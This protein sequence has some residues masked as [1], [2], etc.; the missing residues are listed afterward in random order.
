MFKRFSS[1]RSG[2]GKEA[3]VITHWTDWITLFR[4]LAWLPVLGLL[5][6]GLLFPGTVQSPTTMLASLMAGVL[7]LA[8]GYAFNSIADVAVDNPTKNPLTE[9]RLRT[10]TAILV[11]SIIAL[12]GLFMSLLLSRGSAL[13]FLSG[14]IFNAAYSFPPLRLKRFLWSN[15]ILN[16]AGFTMLA[17]I[18]AL[19]G[20]LPGKELWLLGGFIF[21]SLVPYQIIHLFTHKKSDP[22]HGLPENPVR[23]FFV[24]HSILLV[25]MALIGWLLRWPLFFIA[26][27]VHTLANYF[28]ATRRG[29][30]DTPDP[31]Q[32]GSLRRELRYLSVGWGILLILL[33]CL[34]RNFIIFG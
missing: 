18:G 31:L 32:M 2:R 21:L 33:F 7:F 13:A 6:L 34:Q 30:R 10:W 26:G 25:G 15:L 3:S 17:L 16:S 5:L 19:A 22:I 28:L 11:C 14:V 8:Q 29:L 9:G 12:F 20:R 4:P 24:S 23:L 27:V 1:P